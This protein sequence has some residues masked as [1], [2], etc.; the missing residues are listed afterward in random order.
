[1]EHVPANDIHL[2]AFT[3]NPPNTDPGPEEGPQETLA[4]VVNS[5]DLRI[6]LDKL[7]HVEEA[8]IYQIVALVLNM[9]DAAR[10]TGLDTDTA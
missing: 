8:A 3:T 6:L 9:L 1:M 4:S 10:L 2:A 7:K 5:R